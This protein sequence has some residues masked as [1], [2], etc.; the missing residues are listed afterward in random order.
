MHGRSAQ[1]YRQPAVLNVQ[2]GRLLESVTITS[3]LARTQRQ[4][5]DAPMPSQCSESLRPEQGE[6]L[7]FRPLSAFVTRRRGLIAWRCFQQRE[8]PILLS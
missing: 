6:Q 8:I 2:P 1:C 3:V 5:D 7:T 4:L